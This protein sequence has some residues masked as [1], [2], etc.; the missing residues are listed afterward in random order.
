MTAT[1]PR[2]SAARRCHRLAPALAI[3][4]LAGGL[5]A[6]ASNRLPAPRASL[7]PPAAVQPHPALLPAPMMVDSGPEMFGT[8]SW[9]RPGP[10]L[11]RTCTGETFTRNGMTAASHSIPVGTRVRVALADDSRSIVVR[12]NDCMPRGRRILD[13]S[14]GAAEQ[15]GLVNMG[16]ARVTVT[17]VMLVDNR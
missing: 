9:Y 1:T 10:G 17:P 13:L 7:A 16:I 6:C 3:S 12:V 14:E 2:G 15:L 5:S 4:L 8:A 11:H